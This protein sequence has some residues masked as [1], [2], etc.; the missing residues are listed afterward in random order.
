MSRARDRAVPRRAEPE[1]GARRRRGRREV[2]DDELEGAEVALGVADRPLHHREVPDPVRHDLVRAGQEHGDV[3]L[4]GEPPAGLD[5]GLVAAVD[6]D[7]AAARQRHDRGRGGRGLGRHRHQRR[8]LG[9]GFRAGVAPARGLADVG[10]GELAG[11]AELLGDLGEQR[12]LLRAADR[13]RVGAA[14]DRPHPVELGAAELVAGFDL[15]AAAAAGDAVAVARHAPVAGADQELP[16]LLRSILTPAAQPG[17]A[18]VEA[19]VW[20]HYNPHGTG[21]TTMRPASMSL[22][23]SA[24]REASTC[25]RSTSSCSCARPGT[26]SRMPAPSRSA[27]GAGTLVWVRR[28]DLVEFAVVLEPEE[29]LAPA[30]RAIYAGTNALADALVAH[31]PPERPV[32]FDWPDAIRFDGALV[33]GGRLGWPEGVA[34]HE[35]PPW[36][37]F[38]GMIRASASRGGEPGSRPLNGAL[39][40]LGFEAIDAGA[41]VASFARHLM[42]GFHEWS[43]VGFAPVARRWL[44]RLP[45]QG[46]ERF[47][48]RRQR[49]SAGLSRGEPEARR[50][51]EPG[52]GARRAVLAR[53][54]DGGA[55]ALKLPRTIRLDASDTFVY[56]AGGGARRM[57]GHRHLPVLRRRPGQARRQGAAGVPRRL[58]R[59]RQLRLVDARRRH[60][61]ERRRSGR[62]P[63]SGSPSSSSRIAARPTSKPRAPP[64]RRRSP[65][66]SR[67]ATTSRTRCSGF[68]APAKATASGNRSGPCTGA[69][70]GSSRSA[71]S[72]SSRSRR[73]RRPRRW[74]WSRWRGRRRDEGFL[75]RVRPSSARPGPRRSAARDRRLPEGLPRAPRAAAARD[76]LRGGAAAASRAVDA[77]SAPAGRGRRRSPRSRTPTRARTGGT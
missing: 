7:D 52:E 16:R 10:E 63:S 26:P 49:R 31:A 77:P 22:R 33:G 54:G 55:M 23:P 47:Q 15:G 51:A 56:P 57:G 71:P 44:D 19:P 18:P 36:L 6:Q 25:R 3:E 30:R 45:R 43:E 5:R 64:P 74:T 48:D 13:H 39:D 12:R 58:P 73:R 35:V 65:S 50:A 32:T 37:V 9:A 41:I 17:P 40:E 21:V 2:V 11:E 66:P 72:A 24:P 38:S 70:A 68:S 28:Y 67:C 69:P 61:R 42:A 76:R 60:A 75:G 27:R 14:Q 46:G 1:R 62:P 53:P 8:R 20:K 4:V 29:A 34:E 59:H